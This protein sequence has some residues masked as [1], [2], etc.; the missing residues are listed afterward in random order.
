MTK[1]IKP[2]KKKL[3]DPNFERESLKYENPIPS[4]EM[5]AELINSQGCPMAFKEIASSLE[6]EKDQVDALSR[7]INAMARDAQLIRNR[8]GGYCVVDKQNLIAGRVIGHQDG[9]G[10]LRPDEGGNDLFLGP[11]EMR[12]VWHGDHVVAQ[13][14]GRDQ[15][16][17]FEGVIVEVVER[18]YYDLVGKLNIK[19]GVVTLIPDNKR[20]SHQL[21]IDPEYLLGASDGEIVVAQIIEHPSEFR[22]PFG[23][24]TEILGDNL[25]PGMETDIAIRAHNLPTKWSKNAM[26][27]LKKMEQNIPKKLKDNRFDLT[28][29][30]FITIDGDNAKDFDD[31]VYCE[32]T[33]K[34]W[35]LF[36]AIAD[37]AEYVKSGTPL[38]EEAY[39]RGTSVYFPSR[40]IP[41]LPEK[42]SNGLCSLNPNV[43]RLVVV[44]E[45]YFDKKGKMYRSSFFEGFINSHARVTY[46]EAEEIIFKKNKKINNKFHSVTSHIKNLFEFYKSLHKAREKRGAIDFQTAEIGFKF[47]KTGKILDIAP[48]S[49]GYSHK[50]IEECMLSANVAAA[51]FLIRHKIPSLFRIHERPSLEKLTDLGQ[52]LSEMGLSLRGGLKPSAKDYVYLIKSVKN[53]TDS[54]IIQTVLLRSMMQAVYSHD[55]LGHFGL[56]YEAYAHFTSP[57]RRYPDL[58]VHRA[59]KHIIHGGSGKNF[60]YDIPHLAAMGEHCSALERRADDA[61]RDVIDALK[62]DFMK[63]KVGEIFYGLISGVHGFGLFVEL[64]DIFISG[65]IHIT[66]LD[67]DYF[68]FDPIGH[69]LIGERT[70]KTYRLGDP[71]RVR[72]AAVNMEERKLDF[73][74]PDKGKKDKNLKKT[75]KKKNK[76]KKYS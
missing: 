62:C 13:I 29:L 16:G 4:R 36:V 52:F 30:P 10:F 8:R 22:Q 12:K 72:V 43:D 56:A 7:R 71:I 38:D 58:M 54:H 31:S 48:Q 27:Q 65:L 51:R 14:S 28:E 50:I 68:H 20:I 25:T 57:I 64:D 69:R 32:K 3:V 59:I 46:N 15:K 44:A 2:R 40:V 33:D 9:F 23:K 74:L 70:H 1:R 63:D 35:R 49:R 37:V 47:N 45:M 19:H 39:I 55:N 24:I 17:R 61:S 34:G 66:S 6:I 41:M 21:L 53:R 67:K 26:K 60:K 76:Q 75:R 18:A 73:I 42:I 5:I 11:R